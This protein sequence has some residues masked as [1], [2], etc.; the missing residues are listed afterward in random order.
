MPLFFVHIPKTAGT[1]FRLGAEQAFG[2][3]LIAYDYGRGS[4][5]T[6]DIVK[7][8]LYHSPADFWQ[9]GQARLRQETALVGGHVNIGRFVSL[10]GV[11]QTLT[12]LREPLQRMASEYAHFVRHYEY[13][14]SF[15]DFYSRPIMHNRQSKIL[16]GVDVEAVGFV[17]LTERYVDSLDLINARYGIE[18][19][20]RE[21]NR[22]KKS[23]E[24][25]H[26]IS[27]EDQAELTRLNKQD[28]DLY[29]RAVEL[30]DVRYR[31]FQKGMPWAH[32]RIQE[33]NVQRIAGWAWWAEESDDPVT[34]EVWANGKL[35]DA[36]T[37]VELRPGLCRLLPPRG[38]YVGFHL[39]VKLRPG[40]Q[41]QCR[42]ANSGQWF[43][44]KPRRVPKPE[45]K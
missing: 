4:A 41:V 37:A 14:G 3:A 28:I 9:F 17:G 39:P 33:A 16:H 38:G 45:G 31:C 7:N 30:F 32:A 20:Q 22:G 34:V 18:I 11:G 36:V 40:D 1:S 19:P 42:V 29:Q 12:F 24:A 2:K 23:V 44:L 35:L 5:E 8:H 15:H 27:A 13:K 10:F 26:E 25:V 43:P 21:D 6:S